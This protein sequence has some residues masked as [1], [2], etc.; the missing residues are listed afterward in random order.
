MRNLDDYTSFFAKAQAKQ[1][2]HKHTRQSGEN[3]N[4]KTHKKY[5]AHIYANRISQDYERVKQALKKNLRHKRRWLILVDK[6]VIDNGNSIPRLGLELLLLCEPAV[7][8]KMLYAHL[9]KENLLTLI[10]IITLQD[11]LI[12]I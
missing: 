11:T 9:C 4:N 3:N 7:A 2:I 6:F 5:L 8:R 10:A 1:R 12:L